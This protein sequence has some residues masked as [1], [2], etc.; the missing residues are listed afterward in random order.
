MTAQPSLW[1]APQ[2]QP[3]WR[4][5][6]AATGG[7]PTHHYMAWVTRQWRLWAAETGETRRILDGCWQPRQQARFSRWLAEVWPT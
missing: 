1:D 2:P 6:L 7:G 3:Y 5:W 4:S